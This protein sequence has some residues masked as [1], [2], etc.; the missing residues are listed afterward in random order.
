MSS[1][2][3]RLC[4]TNVPEMLFTALNWMAPLETAIH[5]VQSQSRGKA[6]GKKRSDLYIPW[7]ELA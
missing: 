5:A 4:W 7:N 3:S 6:R 2:V 1:C